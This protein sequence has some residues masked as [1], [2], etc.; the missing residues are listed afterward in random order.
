MKEKKA[1]QSTEIRCQTRRPIRKIGIQEVMETMIPKLQSQ[2]QAVS[3]ELKEC[4]IANNSLL[5]E[6]NK[7]KI[8]IT[9]SKM[10]IGFFENSKRKLIEMLGDKDEKI[11][12]L[13]GIIQKLD[14]QIIK[15]KKIQRTF[16]SKYYRIGRR[17]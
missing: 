8:R 7:Q 6:I 14:D 1:R 16:V 4:E 2:L 17:N 3:D 5:F 10:N 13:E 12:R 11:S 9:T 15:S